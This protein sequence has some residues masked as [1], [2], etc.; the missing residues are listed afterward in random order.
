MGRKE[1]CGY[2]WM[3]QGEFNTFAG[4]EAS[5]GNFLKGP[6]MFTLLW[7]GSFVIFCVYRHNF[8]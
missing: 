4:I 8:C 1:V 2:G 6:D 5:K 7:L 3:N